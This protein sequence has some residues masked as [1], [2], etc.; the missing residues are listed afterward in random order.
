[1]PDDRSLNTMTS[2]VITVGEGG[3][4]FVVKGRYHRLV[5]T[6]AHCLPFLPPAISFSFTEEKTYQDLL[7][8]LGEQPSIW[9]ECMFVDCIADIAILGPPDSQNLGDQSDAY[10][11]LV[12]A[13]EAFEI[14]NPTRKSRASLLSLENQWFKCNVQHLGGP[15]WISDAAAS[16]DACLRKSRRD[17]SSTMRRTLTM[18]ISACNPLDTRAAKQ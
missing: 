2:A 5:I 12:D 17:R 7:A 15:L 3:R 10:E 16:I 14:S 13:G 9:A 6:A 4:G 8:P 11:E 18:S 1:M